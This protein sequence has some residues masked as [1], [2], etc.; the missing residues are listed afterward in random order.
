[1]K[2][3]FLDI[4]GTL[5]S[6]GEGPFAQDIEALE[7][8]RA[9]GHRVFLNTGRSLANI[10]SALLDAPF[11]DGIVA[12][13]GAHVVLERKTVYHRWIAEPVL[14]RASDW[15]L[16]SGKWCIFEGETHIYGIR[17]EA[18]IGGLS[19]HKEILP[20]A[21]A[22]DFSTRYKGALVTKLTMQGR[23]D[24]AE[25]AALEEDFRVT[26]FPDY[27]E[28]VIKG[29]T[30]A[31]GMAVVLKALGIARENSV[32]IGDSLNDMEML[33]FAG[34][35]IAMGNACAPLKR[36]AD[37]VTLNCGAGG[38]ANALRRWVLC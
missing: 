35:G 24:Q 7:Q 13:A 31:G 8:A 10:P 30:K 32:A 27:S 21:A 9:E 18:Y 20:I 38:V 14:A 17:P 11:I 4:D 33:E 19:F 37:A 12:G 2:A 16:R 36:I 23:A 15:Y 1:M 25:R 3:I 22:E 6:K 26:P 34:L 28:A 29:E 5:V